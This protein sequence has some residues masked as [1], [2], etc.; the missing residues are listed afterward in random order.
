[1]VVDSAWAER[2]F[3]SGPIQIAERS[4]P[5][6]LGARAPYAP[7]FASAAHA[8]GHG[9]PAGQ[10]KRIG[11]RQPSKGIKRRGSRYAGLRS[12]EE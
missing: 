7:N 11:K 10:A 2:N 1:M 3:G 6:P 5:M 9:C 4:A 8:V 12:C